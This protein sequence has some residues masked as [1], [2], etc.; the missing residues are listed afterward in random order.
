MISLEQVSIWMGKFRYWPN[1]NFDWYETE[2]QGIWLAI[3]YVTV[4]IDNPEHPRSQ[5]TKSEIP[6][7]VFDEDTFFVWLRWRLERIARNEV[8]AGIRIDG[9]KVWDPRDPRATERP[10]WTEEPALWEP[11]GAELEKLE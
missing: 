10:N 6:S 5:R 9:E 1:V 2:A 3:E 8:H 11:K 7:L 4:D